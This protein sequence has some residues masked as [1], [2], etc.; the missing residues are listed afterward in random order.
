MSV[1]PFSPNGINL[2]TDIE[3]RYSRTT[4][5]RVTKALI[6]T[7]RVPTTIWKTQ[8]FSITTTLTKAPTA[9]VP[10][11][12]TVTKTKTCVEREVET[13]FEACTNGPVV[14][15]HMATVTNAGTGIVTQVVTE[16]VH[17]TE[18]VLQ[19]TTQ[20]VS[21]VVTVTVSD[22]PLTINASTFTVTETVTITGPPSVGVEIATI[23]VSQSELPA[24]L[25]GL[26]TGDANP[27][28]FHDSAGN[29]TSTVISDLP[30][31]PTSSPTTVEIPISPETTPTDPSASTPNVAILALASPAPSCDFPPLALNNT[32]EEPSDISAWSPY[33]F[34]SG[35]S[36]SYPPSS[37]LVPA[38][39]GNRHLKMRVGNSVIMPGA[40]MTATRTI[41]NICSG[42]EYEMSAWV[43]APYLDGSTGGRCSAE[44]WGAEVV[45]GVAGEF[46]LVMGGV[47]VEDGE[48]RMM[49]GSWVQGVGAE[50]VQ[51]R[52][53]V[54][55]VG[56]GERNVY[57]DDLVVVKM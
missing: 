11:P 32:F 9:T 52:F 7:L 24:Y 21:E 4:T 48:W 5:Q 44:F 25:S 34:P 36:A 35:T 14:S 40:R 50:Q 23:T 1:P 41:N 2:L 31:S 27:T 26:T 12:T 56:S 13:V 3:Y 8:R 37:A 38:H 16:T 19:H 53:R 42:A 30:P 47:A 6:T 43:R 51:M 57:M 20:T 39:S 54:Q 18:T 17:V 55:C 29:N 28:A 49:Q 22:P 46:R 33:V 15:T 45:D 10:R